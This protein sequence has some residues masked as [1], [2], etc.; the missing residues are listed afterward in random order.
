[1]DEGLFIALELGISASW[2]AETQVLPAQPQSTRKSTIG[3]PAPFLQSTVE[4]SDG[5]IYMLRLIYSVTYFKMLIEERRANIY[6]TKQG[7]Q[8]VERVIYI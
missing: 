8:D 1:M 7:W 2:D 4:I 5:T 6:Y 3:T